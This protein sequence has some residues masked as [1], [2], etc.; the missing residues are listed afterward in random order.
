MKTLFRLALAGLLALGTVPASAVTTDTVKVLEDSGGV[1]VDYVK[2]YSDMRDSGEKLVIAGECASACT[3]FLGLLPKSQYC[4]TP[5]AALGFHTASVRWTDEHGKEHYEHAIEFSA[6]MWNIY[7]GKV[8]RIV[9]RL[10]WNGDNPKVPHPEVIR[11]KGLI[12]RAMAPA[13]TAEDLR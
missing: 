12:L 9:R 7:P 11:V 3:L 8:R 6:L 4:V 1:I 2:K 13:C 5:D 10:G